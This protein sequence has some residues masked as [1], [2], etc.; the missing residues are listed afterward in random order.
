MFSRSGMSKQSG[1]TSHLTITGSVGLQD[2]RSLPLLS[3][4]H[5]V[6]EIR[7]VC[8]SFLQNFGYDPECALSC[9]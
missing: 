9:S 7:V 5:D 2:L 1:V 3:C 8:C 4:G 6:T